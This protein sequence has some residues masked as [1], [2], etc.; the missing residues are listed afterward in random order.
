MIFFA[1][2]KLGTLWLLNQLSKGM[3]QSLGVNK[4][5]I[6]CSRLYLLLQR[7]VVVQ[8]YL[9]QGRR[10]GHSGSWV[11]DSG[12]SDTGRLFQFCT[13]ANN[14][15]PRVQLS[16][17]IMFNW[18]IFATF[19]GPFV[20]NHVVKVL[21]DLV[22]WPG[23][24]QTDLPFLQ[25]QVLQ[26]KKLF[27]CRVFFISKNCWNE[28]MTRLKA[29]NMGTSMNKLRT[30]ENLTTP[31]PPTLV[32]KWVFWVSCFLSSLKIHCFHFFK[33]YFG[34]KDKT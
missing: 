14:V 23:I 12:D 27:C 21:L 6:V 9:G 5:I 30:I 17:Q 11:L 25:S 10:G 1:S 18:W 20:F 8:P 34:T 32:L 16:A 31:T 3:D 22:Q 15:L 7:G 13:S 2:K 26:F 19:S 33:L 28:F 24:V 29:K 4:I